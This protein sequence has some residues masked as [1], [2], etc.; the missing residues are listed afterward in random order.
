MHVL[1]SVFTISQIFDRRKVGMFYNFH[2]IVQI[3]IIF[4]STYFDIDLIDKP[5]IRKLLWNISGVSVF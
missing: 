5:F 1:S 4:G 2:R 3:L